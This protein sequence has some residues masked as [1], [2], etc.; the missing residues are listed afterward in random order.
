M[1]RHCVGVCSNICV[2]ARKNSRS[3]V[4]RLWEVAR[5]KKLRGSVFTSSQPDV[6]VCVCVCVWK[7]SSKDSFDTLSA[8]DI[9]EQM[10]YLDHQIFM[11][12]K[13]E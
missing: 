7:V 10:T 12:I 5:F 13:S 4:V 3:R 6:C 9:A 2:V 11:A 8:L 1:G